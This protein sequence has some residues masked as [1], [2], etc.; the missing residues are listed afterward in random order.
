MAKEIPVANA[1]A[2]RDAG[3]IPKAD[4]ESKN[5]GRENGSGNA[6]PNCGE[7]GLDAGITCPRAGDERRRVARVT[8]R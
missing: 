1:S 2:P 4:A 5:L 8:L 7:A 3:D 6:H